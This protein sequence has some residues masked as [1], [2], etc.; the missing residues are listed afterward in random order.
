MI[1]DRGHRRTSVR[2][3]LSALI[4]AA[5][6]A[7][8]LTAYAVK[9][10]TPAVAL[11]DSTA[12]ATGVSYTFTGFRVAPN[13][14]V[15]SMTIKF[16]TNTSTV[17]AGTTSSPQGT[18][19]VLDGRTV[20]VTFSPALDEKNSDIVLVLNGVTNPTSA[21]TYSVEGISFSVIN[22][23][24]SPWTDTEVISTTSLPSY[25]VTPAATLSLTI[26]GDVDLGALDV[27]QTSPT[28]TITVNVVTDATQYTI[29]RTVT[30]DNPG[31]TMSLSG[32]YP[33]SGAAPGA[34]YQDVL[35]VTPGWDASPDVP[36]TASV[37][38]TVA[39]P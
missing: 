16:A 15:T 10:F 2:V 30:D 14:T 4:A 12:L 37:T 18:V 20:K 34:T 39:I 19:S 29:T 33:V 27:D 13:Q 36:F 26:S 6:L 3:L 38:Y 17:T 22:D 28:E 1:V 8:P 32:T 31:W 24:P 35:S 5:I 11:S 9:T 21:G 7:A 25:T 23:K